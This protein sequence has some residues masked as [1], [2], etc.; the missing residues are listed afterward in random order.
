MLLLIYPAVTM[1]YVQ[2]MTCTGQGHIQQSSFIVN[3]FA[4]GT[5]WNIF[6]FRAHNENRCGGKPFCLMHSH[7]IHSASS[8][9]LFFI[10]KRDG[11]D[12]QQ[13]IKIIWGR[14]V[15]HSLEQCLNIFQKFRISNNLFR[16]RIYPVN[17]LF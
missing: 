10:V 3:F 6:I 5:A 2:V 8:S 1:G 17:Q 15:Y 11:Y 4:L 13:F 12:P 14:N 9:F 7:N 16:N